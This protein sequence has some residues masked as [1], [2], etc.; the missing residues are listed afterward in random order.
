MEEHI[1]E[2]ILLAVLGKAISVKMRG[3][4]VKNRMIRNIFGQFEV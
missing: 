2:M 1:F 3:L 4:E